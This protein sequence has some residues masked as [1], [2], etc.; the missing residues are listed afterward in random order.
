MLDTLK[1][2]KAGLLPLYLKM[3]DDVQPDQRIGAEAFHAV[4]ASRLADA[5]I[6]TV[7]VPVCRIKEEADD[8]VSL[9]E[10]EGVDC[11]LV[12]NLSYSPSL[13]SVYALSRT[14]LPVILI[15]STPD[16]GF[17]FA[18]A[19][20]ELVYNQGL[21][22]TQDLAAMLRR[23]GKDFIVIPG[24][25][26]D[27]TFVGSM[28]ASVRAAQTG[29]RLKSARVGVIGDPFRGMGDIQLGGGKMKELLGI[30]QVKF[31]LARDP[32]RYAMLSDSQSSEAEAMADADAAFFTSEMSRAQLVES[33]R[34][35]LGLRRWIHD[36]RLDAVTM[37]FIPQPKNN[38]FPH[39]PQLA[40]S[41]LMGEGLGTSGE[42]DLI[43][44][45]L[46]SALMG[47]YTDCT[48][49]SMYCPDW[50]GGTVYLSYRTG[51]NP[52]CLAGKPVICREFEPLVPELP[53]S[54][55]TGPL[56]GGR[57]VI[58]SLSPQDNDRF[59]LTAVTGEMLEVPEN[60][61][62]KGRVSG[63]FRPDTPLTELISGYSENGGP[64]HMVLA[65]GASCQFLAQT[66]R[67]CGFEFLK[68]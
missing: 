11:I 15:A 41:K 13:E 46:C 65:Y 24:H 18:S 43:S 38:P 32:W 55:L 26:D 10:S 9:F 68:I 35:Y 60:A 50:Q 3:Y 28:A 37:N 2:P 17:G 25:S 4:I 8:A 66:A 48:P 36:N 19:P 29:H 57:A 6:E 67:L 27:S 47:L 34:I 20:T 1:P 5:G 59:T 42:G 33:E 40:M 31:D 14:A 21:L 53:V 49:I 52:R 54:A 63:W 58:I 51:V 44:A 64:H 22:G 7:N 16:R 39:V 23:S 30:D 56:R 12:L 45:S 61:R 62:Q